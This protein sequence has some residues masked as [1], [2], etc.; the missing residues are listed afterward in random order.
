MSA[1]H[2]IQEIRS[3]PDLREQVCSPDP[4]PEPSNGD[5]IMDLVFDTIGAGIDMAADTVEAGIDMAADTVEAG[6]GGTSKKGK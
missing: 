3:D 2:T 4:D 1:K 5:G 6:M